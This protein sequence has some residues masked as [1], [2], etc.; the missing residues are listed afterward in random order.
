MDQIYLKAQEAANYIKSQ[1]NQIPKIAL[2]LGTGSSVLISS[3]TIIKRIVYSDI[4]HFPTS[5]VQSHV[6]E[7]I[8]AQIDSQKVI[9]LGG[10][11]HYYEGW[12]MK[13][14]CFPIRVLQALK[15]N[16]I[17]FSNASG[18]LNP[19]YSAGEII[20][21]NDH[22]NMLPD[23]PLRGINDDRLGL[24][25]PDMS[26]SYSFKLRNKL[27]EQYPKIKEGVY[28]SFPGPNLET[29]AEYRMLHRIGGDLVGMSTVPEVIVAKHAGMDV[30]VL[31]I[32]SNI[33]YPPEQITET[34][35]EEVIEVVNASGELLFEY[36]SFMVSAIEESPRI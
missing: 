34:T 35:L 10:R 6:N 14:L 33:C 28:V 3:A 16:V 31:S 32:A 11:M 17:L 4:P 25:F 21:V 18:A 12:S 23:N 24:R 1:V 2:S 13:E 30:M 29:K 36:V 9:I 26:D 15:V 19:N 20:L 8:I 22:I 27:K 5:R 7:L